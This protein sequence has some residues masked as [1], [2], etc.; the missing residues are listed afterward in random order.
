MTG[1]PLSLLSVAAILLA[2]AAVGYSVAGALVPR[3]RAF[4]AERLSW[5]FAAGLALLAGSVAFA[6]SLH[7]TPGWLSFLVL[8]AVVGLPARLFRFRDRAPELAEPP[9][10]AGEHR[11]S[12][13]LLA[14]LLLGVALY[15]LRALTEPMWANDYVAI[16]GFKGKTFFAERHIPDLLRRL[17]QGRQRDRQQGRVVHGRKLEVHA[18]YLPLGG[19]TWPARQG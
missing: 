8:A 7:G 5:G 17:T 11:A 9:E 4:R 18:I 15:A 12:A 14:I 19:R 16:W 6:F 2:A 10:S 1:L 3:G 13:V